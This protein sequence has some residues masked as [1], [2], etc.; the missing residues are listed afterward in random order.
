MT[1]YELKK[2]YRQ[3]KK[4]EICRELTTRDGD[5]FVYFFNSNLD[6]EESMLWIPLADWGEYLGVELEKWEVEVKKIN[7]LI[8]RV[9]I[10]FYELDKKLDAIDAKLNKRWF[11]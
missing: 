7:T 6:Y 1:V 9:C 4:G 8:E 5:K 11:F 10:A 3:F 2:D